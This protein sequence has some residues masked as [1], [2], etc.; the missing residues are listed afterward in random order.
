MYEPAIIRRGGAEGFGAFR[1]HKGD[2]VLPITDL[3][4]RVPDLRNAVGTVLRVTRPD[5][6]THLVTVAWELPIGVQELSH[7][8][9]Y[10][11][12]QRDG[13]GRP[14]RAVEAKPR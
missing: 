10:L 6:R 12:P 4:R 8:S 11:K 5:N 2:R 9:S 7:P 14:L 13:H 3:A 1:Y